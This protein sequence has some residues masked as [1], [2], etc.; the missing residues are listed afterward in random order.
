MFFASTISLNGEAQERGKKGI[1]A[2][3]PVFECQ[4]LQSLL[5]SSM[6]RS[7]CSKERAF[8]T[9]G[10]VV[11]KNEPEKTP[12]DQDQILLG[13]TVLVVEDVIDNQML[14]K[15]YLARKG[16]KV[17]FANNGSEG[18]KKAL[19]GFFDLILMDM[20]MPVM[21]GYT[22]TRELR[23]QG[24]QKPI[25]ALTAHAMKEDR[26]KCLQA[27]CDD[28]LT[29]PLDSKI[30]Y[31]ALARNLWSYLKNHGSSGNSR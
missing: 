10:K 14:T 18:V 9:F 20:Q 19:E 3:S 16:M 11:G 6:L 23:T 22:A 26:A 12:D 30:L 21:D 27:G 31:E 2:L 13:K 8:V 7:G 28:Y 1:Q 24:Y 15:L 17:Q 5:R 25:I 4:S 29:K